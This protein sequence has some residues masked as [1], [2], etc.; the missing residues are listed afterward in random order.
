MAHRQA[1]PEA[2]GR[3]SPALARLDREESLMR[4]D[5][6]SSLTCHCLDSTLPQHPSPVQQ[7]SPPASSPFLLPNHDLPIG[8]WPGLGAPLRGLHS[9]HVRPAPPR[10][11]S[12]CSDRPGPA[13]RSGAP[14]CSVAFIFLS[15]A[16]FLL[17]G[18]SLSCSATIPPEP[19]EPGALAGCASPERDHA[20]PGSARVR[21][22]PDADVWGPAVLWARAPG[23]G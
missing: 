17:G 6:A 7:P 1:R 23:L 2:G 8:L 5:L 22:A 18:S 3:T 20:G 14:V 12:A 16:R 15:L 10:R 11:L 21:R 13:R 19:D 4:H 9:Q